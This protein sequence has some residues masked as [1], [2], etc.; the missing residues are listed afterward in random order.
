MIIIIDQ[1]SQ[2]IYAYKTLTAACKL[3]PTPKGQ[4]PLYYDYLRTIRFS[5]T[6]TK[7]KGLVIYKVQV[8]E[9]PKIIKHRTWLHGLI[10]PS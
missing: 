10:E 9:A 4:K 2:K 5:D 8:T 6:P 3:H 1:K 7:H